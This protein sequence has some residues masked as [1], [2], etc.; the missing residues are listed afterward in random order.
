MNETSHPAPAENAEPFGSVGAVVVCHNI[1]S[2]IHAAL[3]PLYG[4]VQRIALVDNGSDAQTREI[5]GIIAAQ[6]PEQV[7]LILRQDGNLAA[8][9]NEGVAALL[10]QGCDWVLL[11]DH[12]SLAA[13]DMVENM[14]AAWRAHPA[15]D[16]I[17]VL[18]PRVVD[19]DSEEPLAVP[20]A[21]KRIVPWRSRF[22]ARPT[23][24]GAMD[25]LASGSLIP[26]R[27]FR[28]IG[29]MDETLGIDYVDKDF[30][31]RALKTGYR[32][33]AVRG[34]TLHHRLGERREHK[35]FGRF[36]FTTLNH[37]PERRYTIYRNRLRLWARHG[38]DVP[39]FF[40]YD[41]AATLRDLIRILAF[42]DRRPAKFRAILKGA[43]DAFR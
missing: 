20:M 8:G 4:Q 43:L 14:A 29:M 3:K 39:A 22:G 27:V 18:A 21:W 11:L 13:E 26:A 42:E 5:L 10:A 19:A 37:S 12:D 2:R 7:T 16:G 6:K 17:G 36:R 33:V 15:K 9:Q 31:L 25:A 24:D 41:L 28:H 30:C 34:A 23:L 38:I 40:F 32:I 35:I 1:G